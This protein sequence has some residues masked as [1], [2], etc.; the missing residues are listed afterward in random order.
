[1]DEGGRGSLLHHG[2]FIIKVFIMAVQRRWGERKNKAHLHMMTSDSFF[3][4]LPSNVNTEG[5]YTDN[6]AVHFIVPLADPLILSSEW[7]TGLSKVILSE[8]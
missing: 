4:Y 6:N 1:M 5:Q 7:E 2:F 3:V 8:L